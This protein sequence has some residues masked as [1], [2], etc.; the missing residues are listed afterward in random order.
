MLNLD[1]VLV[2]ALTHETVFFDAELRPVVPVEGQWFCEFEIHGDEVRAE[3]LVEYVGEIGD[4]EW[5]GESFEIITRPY[6]RDEYSESERRP[7]GAVL[8]LQH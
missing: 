5:N 7:R 4:A 6:V 2:A 8:I 3:A 1:D